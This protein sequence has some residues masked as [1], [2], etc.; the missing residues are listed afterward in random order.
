MEDLKKQDAIIVDI[1]GTIAL[2]GKG[3]KAR[4]PFDWDRVEEDTTNDPVVSLVKSM[5]LCRVA[6][7]L[8]TGRDER[9]SEGTKAW[10]KKHGIHW[11]KLYMKQKGSFEK[12]T[13]SKHRSYIEEI[14]PKYN[15]LFSLDDEDKIVAMWR[16][17]GLTC[18]QVSECFRSKRG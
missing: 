17:I 18:L 4:K 9:A 2:M 5:S 12:S 1:D 16:A 11:D 14:L 7:I 13:I 15:V 6:I 10:L 3:P 8:L